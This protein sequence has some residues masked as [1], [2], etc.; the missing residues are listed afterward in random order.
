MNPAKHKHLFLQ[1]YVK[2]LKFS[3]YWYTTLLL[4]IVTVTEAGTVPVVAAA[5]FPAVVTAKQVQNNSKELFSN[6]C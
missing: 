3:C 4:V 6:V 5:A 1:I 2:Y